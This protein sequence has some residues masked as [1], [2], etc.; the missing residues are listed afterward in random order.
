MGLI[1]DENN[2]RR[3]RFVEWV[4]LTER[5]WGPSF[6]LDLERNTEKLMFGDRWPS[7]DSTEDWSQKLLQCLSSPIIALHWES[8]ASF[9]STLLTRKRVA[10]HVKRTMQEQLH[11]HDNRS[12]CFVPTQLPISLCRSIGDT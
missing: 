2:S 10:T 6:K 5:E 12:R 4:T 9:V 3:R 11:M 7:M 8:K 1:R